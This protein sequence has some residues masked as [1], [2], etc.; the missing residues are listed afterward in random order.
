MP[1]TPSS[2]NQTRRKGERVELPWQLSP[3]QR[4]TCA[5][6]SPATILWHNFSGQGNIPSLRTAA[7]H[8]LPISKHC[9]GSKLIIYFPGVCFV[10]QSLFHWHLPGLDLYAVTFLHCSWRVSL[11]QM[12][13]GRGLGRQKAT[14]SGLSRTSTGG[15]LWTNVRKN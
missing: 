6:P 15:L 5:S 1:F 12:A 8:L 7:A 10:C 2:V 4:S 14:P 3:S 11:G 13:P 9:Q